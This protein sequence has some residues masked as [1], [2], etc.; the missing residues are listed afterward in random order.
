MDDVIKT[1][2]EGPD[3]GPLALRA[4]RGT[5]ET[6][7]APAIVLWRCDPET[8]LL[9]SEDAWCCAT[10]N[11]IWPAGPATVVLDENN[12][13]KQL[14]S[15]LVGLPWICDTGMRARSGY[16]AYPVCTVDEAWLSSLVALDALDGDDATDYFSPSLVEEWE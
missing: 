3:G 1:S 4:F 8:G 15:D 2:I 11:G 5:Y 12:M 9:T 13:G 6:T 14:T 10:V 7:G 16:C